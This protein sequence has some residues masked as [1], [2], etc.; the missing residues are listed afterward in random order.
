MFVGAVVR[1]PKIHAGKKLKWVEYLTVLISVIFKLQVEGTLLKLA[2]FV[3]PFSI[4][5]FG[6]SFPTGFLS[7]SSCRVS[8]PAAS[9]EPPSPQAAQS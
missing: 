5:G 1:K 9:S 3:C 4:P 6:A 2:L 8:V 7:A